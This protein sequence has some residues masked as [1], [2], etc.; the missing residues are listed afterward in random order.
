MTDANPHPDG[1]RY[2]FVTITH[3]GVLKASNPFDIMRGDL[4]TVLRC[5]QYILEMAMSMSPKL[6]PEKGTS[7]AGNDDLDLDDNPSLY[8]D[9]SDDL[10]GDEDEA[11]DENDY[12]S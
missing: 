1:L 7:E 4:A 2:T 8:H 5:L 12:Y 10:D 3:E 11:S 6:T 9:D